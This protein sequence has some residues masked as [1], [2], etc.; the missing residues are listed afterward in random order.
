M[1]YAYCELLSYSVVFVTSPQ[2]WADVRNGRVQPYCGYNNTMVFT[3]STNTYRAVHSRS[4]ITNLF[5]LSNHE[6]SYTTHRTDAEPSLPATFSAAAEDTSDE[7]YIGR[8][9]QLILQMVPPE[10]CNLLILSL[11]TCEVMIDIKIHLILTFEVP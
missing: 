1:E 8:Q 6:V 11:S 7:D 3:T 10:M 4:L 5:N 2:L 9:Q